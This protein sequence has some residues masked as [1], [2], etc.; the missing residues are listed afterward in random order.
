MWRNWTGT[1]ALAD[2]Q[3]DD[4]HMP[5]VSGTIVIVQESRFQLALDGGGTRLFV[6]AHDAPVEPGQLLA[7]QRQQSRIAVTYHSGSN[8]IAGEAHAIATA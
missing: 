1:D 4:N 7:L 3:Q 2:R 8:L 6:L 5:T